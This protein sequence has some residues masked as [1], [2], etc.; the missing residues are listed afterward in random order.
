MTFLSTVAA[1]SHFGLIVNDCIASLLLVVEEA[2]S[3]SIYAMFETW[4][5]LPALSWCSLSVHLIDESKNEQS[6]GL[7]KPCG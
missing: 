1:S 5:P 2:D 4:H 7:E 6:P 3:L